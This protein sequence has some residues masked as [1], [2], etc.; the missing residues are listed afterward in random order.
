MPLRGQVESP[1]KLN[2]VPIPLSSHSVLAFRPNSITLKHLKSSR[3]LLLGGYSIS[4]KQAVTY[5]H[6]DL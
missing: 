6:I 5:L 1:V 4:V 2:K 3:T